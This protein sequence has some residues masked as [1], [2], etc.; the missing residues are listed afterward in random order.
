MKIRIEDDIRRT[1]IK[2]IYNMKELNK[3]AH[4]EI[5]RELE[6]LRR[7]NSQLELYS[8]NL[9]FRKQKDKIYNIL[10]ESLKD[11]IFNLSHTNTNNVF[12][13]EINQE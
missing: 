9:P 5:I 11:N 4:L 6:N 8:N 1:I 7:R 10:I 2:S 3:T 13:P 12:I